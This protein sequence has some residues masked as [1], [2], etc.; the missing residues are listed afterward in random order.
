MVDEVALEATA[1][2][3]SATN[4]A[5]GFCWQH[6][7][8]DLQLTIN[9]QEDAE[10]LKALVDEGRVHLASELTV[11]AIGGLSRED[12]RARAVLAAPSTL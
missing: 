3:E 4:E 6:V 12:Y 9:S 1:R 8:A 10:A 5:A 11:M 2:Y 7:C